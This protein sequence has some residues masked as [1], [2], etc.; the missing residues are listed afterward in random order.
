MRQKNF[1]RSIRILLLLM[2]MVVSKIQ[3]FCGSHQ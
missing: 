1:Q 3:Q 2:I